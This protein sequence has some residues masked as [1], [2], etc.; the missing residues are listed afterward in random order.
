MS[1]TSDNWRAAITKLLKMTSK[2]ELRWER[3][4]LYEGDV[5]T[6]V[7]GSFMAEIDNKAYVISKTRTKDYVDEDEFYWSGSYDFSIFE[8]TL[9][10]GHQKIATAPQL[11]SLSGLYEAAESNMAFNRNALGGLLD[12]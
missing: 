4:Q 2:N 5:W 7:D 11:S 3:S 1:Y 8:N 9:F 10:E 12:D 6:S